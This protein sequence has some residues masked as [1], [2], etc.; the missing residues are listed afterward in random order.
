MKNS[1]VRHKYSLFALLI[2]GIVAT[3]V[4]WQLPTYRRSLEDGSLEYRLVNSGYYL[5]DA[6]IIDRKSL[7]GGKYAEE[8][9]ILL[10]I[11]R[12]KSQEMVGS[13]QIFTECMQLQSGCPDTT[14]QPF[15]YYITYYGKTYIRANFDGKIEKRNYN[16]ALPNLSNVKD[17][18]DYSC[19]MRQV[20]NEEA[21]GL[22]V[23]P[24]SGELRYHYYDDWEMPR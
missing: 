11:P 6:Q 17:V 18:K 13:Q 19:T 23:N 1:L 8:A 10:R 12:Q 7:G 2:L 4:I 9:E 5:K 20:S 15:D 3:L 24:K 21:Y 16:P 14:W 22:C